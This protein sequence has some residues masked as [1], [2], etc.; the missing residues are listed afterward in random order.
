[1][2]IEHV[3][4]YIYILYIDITVYRYIRIYYC[5]LHVYRTYK[6]AYVKNKTNTHSII[7][8]NVL[9]FVRFVTS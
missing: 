3:Y 9:G 1:M 8:K 5:I 6:V 7:N 4:I 2:Y